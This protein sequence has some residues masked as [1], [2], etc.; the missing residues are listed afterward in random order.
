MFTYLPNTVEVKNTI[1]PATVT[2]S[3]AAVN[4]TAIDLAQYDAAVLVSLYVSILSAGTAVVTV[5]E[6]STGSSAW[7]TIAASAIVDPDTGTA[8][9]FT[10]P[11]AAIVNQTLAVKKETLKRY[12]R[13]TITPTGATGSFT[14]F[15]TGFKRNY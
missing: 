8:T 2:T 4:G 14:A 9:A 12:L 1:I 3:S 5:E 15:V 6:S 10:T 11:G 13:V 7:T